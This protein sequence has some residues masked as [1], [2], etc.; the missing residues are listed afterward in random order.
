MQKQVSQVIHS[1]DCFVCK[2]SEI[3]DTFTVFVLF[4]LQVQTLSEK[5]LND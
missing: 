3:S 2:I 1:A 4:N 5:K